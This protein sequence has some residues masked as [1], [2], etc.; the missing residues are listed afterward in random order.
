[1]NMPSST[2]TAAASWAESSVI[3]SWQTIVCILW[4]TASKCGAHEIVNPDQ[5]CKYTINV[6]DNQPASHSIKVNMYGKSR[7]KDNI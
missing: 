3:H 2:F 5:G 1:M 6:W 4:K 7:F